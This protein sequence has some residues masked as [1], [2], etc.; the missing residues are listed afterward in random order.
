[1]QAGT[2]YSK[3]SD[4]HHTHADCVAGNGIRWENRVAGKGGRRL[5]WFCSLLDSLE[6]FLQTY[7]ESNRAGQAPVVNGKRQYPKLSPQE[8]GRV[9]AEHT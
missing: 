8:G 7:Y 4:V 1:M 9:P 3:L 2:W 5:C 6:K